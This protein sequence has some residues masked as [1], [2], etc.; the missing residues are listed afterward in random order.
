MDLFDPGRAQNRVF[1]DSRSRGPAFSMS[2]GNREERCPLLP[3]RQ[4]RL[5]RSRSGLPGNLPVG[6]FRHR[7]VAQSGLK[8]QLRANTYDIQTNPV[9][10]PAR[11]QHRLAVI[12]APCVPTL[13]VLF[14]RAI[15]LIFGNFGKV[16]RIDL[17]INNGK[18]KG[19]QVR[20]QANWLI[21]SLS[22]V[23]FTISSH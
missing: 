4:I 10:P 18:K 7:S 8:S 12:G 9:K 19:G 20:W 21:R 16:S 14:L 2:A 23:C 11:A 15:S 1:A 22:E 5:F 17:S 13:S 6:I 3:S